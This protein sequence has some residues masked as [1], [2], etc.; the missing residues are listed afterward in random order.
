M[1]SAKFEESSQYLSIGM[2]SESNMS[3]STLDL[4]IR[5]PFTEDWMF[6]ARKSAKKF[7]KSK[8]SEKENA[9]HFSIKANKCHFFLCC[10]Y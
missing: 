5:D 3:S 9:R 7:E 8:Q 2:L 6:N 1:K 10:C 4:E